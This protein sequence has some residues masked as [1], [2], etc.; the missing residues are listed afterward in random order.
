ENEA[1]SFTSVSAIAVL[2][3]QVNVI[4]LQASDPEGDSDN[5]NGLTY[6]LSGGVDQSLFALDT[7]TGILTFLAV[8]D[9]EAPTDANGDNT[10]EVQITVTDAGGLTAIQDLS[11]SV[12]YSTN[13]VVDRHIFYDDSL[14]DTVSDD[15]AIASDKTALRA[16]ETAAFENYSSYSKGLNGIMI[17]VLGLNGTPVAA[18]FD[19]RVGNVDDVTGWTLAPAPTSITVRLGAGTGGTDRL[20]ITWADQAIQNQWLQVTVKATGTT[21]LDNDDTFF[22]GHALGETGN[23]TADA[24]VN[25]TDEI[26]VRNDPHTLLNP[27]AITNA[28]DINRDG[29]VDGTDQILVRMNNTM[30]L[31]DLNLIT[32][33]IPSGLDTLNDVALR[34]AS[35]Q[36]IRPARTSSISSADLAGP[37]SSGGAP[38][39]ASTRLDADTAQPRLVLPLFRSSMRAVWWVGVS[40]SI[41]GLSPELNEMRDDLV[42]LLSGAALHVL[43]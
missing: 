43:P 24:Q 18:D 32:P 28:H 2:E 27:A 30:F 19:F 39:N 34:P 40:T 13:Q 15:A 22:F 35:E 1:P 38:A 20:I 5:G 10:Y 23:A 16:G 25:A 7:Q 3:N 4:D 26:A 11:V 29:K 17:D 8:P 33:V 36:L 37:I 31:N 42:S 9:F 6:S 41:D 21:A 14:F 12:V